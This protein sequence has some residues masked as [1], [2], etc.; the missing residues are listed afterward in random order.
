MPNIS[1]PSG[2]DWDAVNVGRS[3]ASGRKAVPKSAAG[4]T[5]AKASGLVATERKHGA[6]GNRSAHSGSGVNAKK[7][8]ES[9]ELKHAKVDKSLSKAIMQARMAKKMTQKELATAINEKPQVIG[10]YE[11][12]KAIPNPQIISKMERKLGCKLPRP[13][14]KPAAKKTGA[15]AKTTGRGGGTVR[16]AGPPQRGEMG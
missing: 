1:M 9:D 15:G 13:G 4:I 8:E 5:A 6:G 14:K 11:S 12:G 16:G 2:Q 7:L 3:G 10:E